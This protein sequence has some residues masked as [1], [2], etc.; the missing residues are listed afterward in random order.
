MSGTG[1]IKREMGRKLTRQETLKRCIVLFACALAGSA[2]L[3]FAIKAVLGAAAAM[4][5]GAY[6]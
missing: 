3:A 2:A 6:A 5:G 4:I 1:R